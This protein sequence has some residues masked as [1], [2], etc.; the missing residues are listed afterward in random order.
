MSILK[1]GMGA[2]AIVCVSLVSYILFFQLHYWYEEARPNESRVPLGKYLLAADLSAGT[3]HLNG[4][5]VNVWVRH[6]ETNDQTPIEISIACEDAYLLVEGAVVKP[7]DPSSCR[8]GAGKTGPSAYLRFTL[9]TTEPLGITLGL[10]PIRI[11]AENGE[12]T[13]SPSASIA[14]AR[15]SK[16]AGATFH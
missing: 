16:R 7:N 9:P 3:G 11:R 12:T 13:I 4:A 10:P 15:K 1:A 2:A 8:D 5:M 6:Q 14:F